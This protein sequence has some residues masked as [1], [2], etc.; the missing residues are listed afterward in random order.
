MHS[1]YEGF[2]FLS[3]K[4]SG[5]RLVSWD[6]FIQHLDDLKDFALWDGWMGWNGWNGV[7]FFSLLLSLSMCL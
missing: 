1:A 7:L 5:G 6:V 4:V 2:V 3:G